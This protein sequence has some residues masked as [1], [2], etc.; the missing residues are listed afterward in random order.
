MWHHVAVTYD[1]ATLRLYVDGSLDGSVAS[2]VSIPDIGQGV[3]LGDNVR[4]ELDEVAV[5]DDWLTAA[6][7]QSH[8]HA[9]N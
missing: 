3:R 8:Y 5:Y 9:R 4:R 1:G 2:A 6:Q 7:V